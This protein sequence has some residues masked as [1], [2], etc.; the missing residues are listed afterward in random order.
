MHQNRK[1]LLVGWLPIIIILYLVALFGFS[2]FD[3]VAIIGTVTGIA[4]MMF[5]FVGLEIK[6]DS[7][8]KGKHER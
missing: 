7:K 1:A 3:Q 5:W 8:K 4:L 6:D 2:G